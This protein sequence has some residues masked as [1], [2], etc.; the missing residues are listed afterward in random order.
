VDLLAGQADVGDGS[1]RVPVWNA[2]SGPI[3]WTYNLAPLLRRVVLL[4]D[5]PL[6]PFTLF[7]NSRRRA[8]RS[9]CGPWG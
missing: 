3:V 6:G 2:I 9:P 8:L 7:Q 5:P 4:R 1:N